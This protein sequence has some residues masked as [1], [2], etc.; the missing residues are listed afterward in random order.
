MLIFQKHWCRYFLLKEFIGSYSSIILDSVALYAKLTVL[1]NRLT[2]T[3]PSVTLSHIS[4]CKQH[5]PLGKGHF[6]LHHSV[7]RITEHLASLSPFTKCQENLSYIVTTT[8]MSTNFRDGDR[9]SK[10][11]PPP[12]TKKCSIERKTASSKYTLCTLS[13]LGYLG[14][15]NMLCSTLIFF[16]GF[17]LLTGMPLFSF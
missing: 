17:F 8:Y 3:F 1:Q 12:P 9:T 13:K 10:S 16:I 6:L 7:P 4:H 11:E 2:S 14:W 15:S 5:W